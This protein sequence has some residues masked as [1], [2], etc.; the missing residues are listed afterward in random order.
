MRRLVIMLIIV[1]LLAGI[2]I[3]V[4]NNYNLTKKADSNEFVKSFSGWA[5]KVV[6]NSASLVGNA[7]G[8][9]WA[10]K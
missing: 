2:F 6:T 1:I 5:V 8:M 10:P 3:I 4:T 9:D 7:I